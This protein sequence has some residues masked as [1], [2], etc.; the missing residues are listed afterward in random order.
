M[1]EFRI[2][3]PDKIREGEN[4]IGKLERVRQSPLPA[5]G[6]LLQ[7]RERPEVWYIMRG[8]RRHIT[9]LDIFYKMG[10]DLGF[11]WGDQKPILEKDLQAIPLGDPILKWPEI[12][13]A[14]P[15][16]MMYGVPNVED[17][18]L[19]QECGCNTVF[20]TNFD[21]KLPTD[22][23]AYM[24]EAKRLSLQVTWNLWGG[25]ETHRDET[26]LRWKDDPNIFTWYFITEPYVKEGG[27][28]LN[29][30]QIGERYDYLLKLTG[31]GKPFMQDRGLFHPH[32]EYWAEDCLDILMPY[33]Y[34]YE[35]A[36]KLDWIYDRMFQNLISLKT[37][38]YPTMPLIQC[39]WKDD[40]KQPPP[41]AVKDQYGR[42]ERFLRGKGWFG[43]HCA[44]Y[45]WE[46]YEGRDIKHNPYLYDEIKE[47]NKDF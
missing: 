5:N 35:F 43:E 2:I 41:G 38:A 36:E 39:F 6:T 4:F 26:I 37:W 29:T 19:V 10:E 28:Y 17:L 1:E 3:L 30:K 27:C 33:S 13:L 18:Q 24:T 42:W 31:R 15:V 23:V 8:E 16:R 11:K 32:A 21:S 12:S 14:S 46:G 34:A 9:T 44:F 20:C 22:Q 25:D 45:R 40:Y 7:V 47:L